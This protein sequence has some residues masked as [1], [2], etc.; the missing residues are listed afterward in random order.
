MPL[1]LGTGRRKCCDLGTIAVAPS[2][3]QR[4]VSYCFRPFPLSL[5]RAAVSQVSSL[6]RLDSPRVRP[7][8]HKEGG[9]WAWAGAPAFWTP[10]CFLEILTG[11]KGYGCRGPGWWGYTDLARS[12]CPASV[13]PSSCPAADRAGYRAPGRRGSADWQLAREEESEEG[14]APERTRPREAG[15]PS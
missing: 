7:A 14:N 12:G 15:P 10:T 8:P 9:G 6:G 11:R 4:F 3:Q 1:S 13:G 2:V 5:P